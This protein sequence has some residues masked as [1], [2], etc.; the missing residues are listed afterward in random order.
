MGLQELQ[1]ALQ[2]MPRG[3]GDWLRQQR[4]AR[5]LTLRALAQEMGI[6]PLEVSDVEHGRLDVEDSGASCD[7][8]CEVLGVTPEDFVD[9]RYRCRDEQEEWA[10]ANPGAVQ[11]LRDAARRPD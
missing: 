6:S 8:W 10:K 4:E 7:R 3:F 1:S 9:A 5:R 11:W 2:R